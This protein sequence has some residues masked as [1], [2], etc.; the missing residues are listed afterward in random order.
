MFQVEA[1]QENTRRVRRDVRN[2]QDTGQRQ[3]SVLGQGHHQG[4]RRREHENDHRAAHHQN[5]RADHIVQPGDGHAMEEKRDVE[6]Q[7]SGR[8]VPGTGVDQGRTVDRL[9]REIP[10]LHNGTPGT[11]LRV[12]FISIN[13]FLFFSFSFFPLPDQQR[14][15]VGHCGRTTF[16]PGQLHVRRRERAR[17]RRNRLRRQRQRSVLLIRRSN[18]ASIND[19]F[20]LKFFPPVPPSPPK[21]TVHLEETDSLQLKWIDTAESDT[22]ILGGFIARANNKINRGRAQ[23]PIPALTQ[24]M[25]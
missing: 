15:I 12:I 1:H 22:P 18:Y 6:L 19:I 9:Q 2:V 4:R 17:Q 24:F 14:R 23:T 3:I 21:L 8:T 20:N 7:E 13:L 5:S 25:Y 11:I 10:G 16:G